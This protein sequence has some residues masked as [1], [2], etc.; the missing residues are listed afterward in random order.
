MPR[1]DSA[2]PGVVDG[3]GS[4]YDHVVMVG[5]VPAA[6]FRPRRVR[7]LLLVEL[8][9][10]AVLV[11]ACI[12]R[13][14]TNYPGSH[15]NTG[16]NAAWLGVEWSM[17]PHSLAQIDALARKL[18]TEQI[19][20]IFVYVSYLKADGAFNP[21]YAHA[22]EFVSELKAVAPDLDVQAWLCRFE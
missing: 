11:R 4:W 12:L 16:H 13:P 14:S 5:L 1:A 3:G 7:K 18:Q 9:L 21:T 2:A 17:E 15:F 6:R 20:T 10:L 8:V 19:S 22:A